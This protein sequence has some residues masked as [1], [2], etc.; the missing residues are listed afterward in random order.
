MTELFV[1]FCSYSELLQSA[2]SNQ[3]FTLTNQQISILPPVQH[4]SLFE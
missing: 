2:L 3:H 1:T 4:F